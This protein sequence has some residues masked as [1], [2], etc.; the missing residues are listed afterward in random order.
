MHIRRHTRRTIKAEMFIFR[1]KRQASHFIFICHGICFRTLVF[2]HIKI[3][4]FTLSDM[5]HIVIYY[6]NLYIHRNIT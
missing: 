3:E 2:L 4:T 1:M 5:T 6:N